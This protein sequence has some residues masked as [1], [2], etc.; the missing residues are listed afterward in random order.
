MS[1]KRDGDDISWLK[2][3]RKRRINE[4]LTENIPE[5][6]AF[7]MKNGMFCCIVCNSQ[8]TCESVNAL[9]IHRNGKK[10]IA[11]DAIFQKKKMEIANLKFKRSQIGGA[12]I[13][14]HE[15]Q[16][17]HD[18]SNVTKTTHSLL[19]NKTLSSSSS[20]KKIK[21]SRKPKLDINFINKTDSSNS[22]SFVKSILLNEDCPQTIN[23]YKQM[24]ETSS[25]DNISNINPYVRKCDQ[26][27]N[28][29]LRN[30]LET[31]AI[32]K[33]SSDKDNL[34]YKTNFIDNNVKFSIK[35]GNFKSNSV[36]SNATAINNTLNMNK[37]SH[38]SSSKDKNDSLITSDDKINNI[39][40]LKKY[41]N[42]TSSGWKKDNNS[43]WVKDEDV[44]FD[45]DEEAPDFN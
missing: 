41:L 17:E 42:A 20:V 25:T 19:Y 15:E 27:Y 44:E 12:L 39:N 18:N 1:F 5:D 6:E 21:S 34:E 3:H 7:L 13:P 10:H 22:A 4:L 40:R 9:A 28:E 43:Q 45:S 33:F 36:C 14:Y 16:K 24:A 35:T 29:Y 2:S 32:Q 30:S 37:T 31:G 26:Y 38:H 8:K 23:E 11:N